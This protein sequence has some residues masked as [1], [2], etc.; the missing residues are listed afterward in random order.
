M[1]LI[2]YHL[3]ATKALSLP[4]Q[5]FYQRRA[6]TRRRIRDPDTA[7]RMVSILLTASP[8]P[9]EMIAPACPM[10]QPGG[11]VTPTM[12]PTVG[13]V[14]LDLAKNSTA[15][16]PAVPPI[17]MIDFGEKQLQEVDEFRALDRIAANADADRRADTHHGR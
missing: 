14:T 17:M 16:F 3:N 8:P 15:S 9:P 7:E 4:S 6:Q 5:Q 1:R 2:G 10:R 12:K 11:A 13:F